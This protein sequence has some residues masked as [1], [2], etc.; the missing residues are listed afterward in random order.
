MCMCLLINYPIAISIPDKFI[1][2]QHIYS[3]FGGSLNPNK[4]Q[5]KRIKNEFFQKTAS[6]LGI[7]HQFFKSS[8]P[9]I[10]WHF[11]K[12]HF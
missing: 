6:K 9:K 10:K 8:P 1:Y 4:E 12:I 7:K 3:T 5:Q 11:R 2:P